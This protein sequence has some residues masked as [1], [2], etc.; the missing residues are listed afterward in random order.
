MI[1]FNFTG[2][3]FGLNLGLNSCPLLLMA[4]VKF[5]VK[6]IGAENNQEMSISNR[7]FV[8]LLTFLISVRVYHSN[9][10][11]FFISEI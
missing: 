2:Q 11:R 5:T 10:R 9:K 3:D 1:N 6:S 7:I 8:N 4:K